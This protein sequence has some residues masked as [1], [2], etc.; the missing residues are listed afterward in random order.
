VFGIAHY[1]A[2]RFFHLLRYLPMVGSLFV[3]RLVIQCVK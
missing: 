3:A 2:L 1:N